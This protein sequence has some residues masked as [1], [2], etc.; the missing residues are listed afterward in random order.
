ML[1]LV[2]QKQ[3]N[4]IILTWA[5]CQGFAVWPQVPRSG[6]MPSQSCK[7]FT[8]TLISEEP[9]EGV[10]IGLRAEADSTEFVVLVPFLPVP[11]SR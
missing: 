1:D 6:P 4:I 5:W 11:G 3:N 8:V 10:P 7:L 9:H 2:L